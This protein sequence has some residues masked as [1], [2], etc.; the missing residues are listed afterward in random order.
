MVNSAFMEGGLDHTVL[1]RIKRKGKM[2]PRK[3]QMLFFPSC[4][5]PVSKSY[6]FDN[7]PLH[8]ITQFLIILT[9]IVASRLVKDQCP[10]LSLQPYKS[11]A[12]EAILTNGVVDW[13]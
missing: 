10:V 3:L 6:F 4:T 8:C 13:Y 7:V 12:D 5:F 11:I 9:F 2:P 1:I